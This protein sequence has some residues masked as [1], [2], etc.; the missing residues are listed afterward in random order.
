MVEVV[1]VA[2]GGRPLPQVCTVCTSHQTRADARRKLAT[3]CAKQRR[4][5]MALLVGWSG[6]S[7]GG[8]GGT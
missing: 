3:S 4:T 2:A 5:G 8:T 6:W 7:E 1:E